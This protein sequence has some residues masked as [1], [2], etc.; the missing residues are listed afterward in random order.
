MVNFLL[1]EIATS[2]KK[3]HPERSEGSKKG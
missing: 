1:N 2:L 3:C